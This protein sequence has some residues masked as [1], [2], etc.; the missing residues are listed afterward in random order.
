MSRTFEGQVVVVTGAGNGLGRSYAHWLA[1]AG[2]KVVVNNRVREGRP[3]SAQQ[4]VAEILAA[5]GTAVADENAIDDSV[6]ASRTINRAME[7]WGRLD[8]LICNAGLTKVAPLLDAP[9]SDIHEIMNVNFF[10]TLY[11]MLAAARFMRDAGYGR[12]VATTSS[13]ACFPMAGTGAYAASKSALI[14][15]VRTLDKE[16]TDQN[17]RV[18][19]IAPR[20]YTTM[21][22]GYM[23]ES[24][25]DIFAPEAVAR[26][27]AWLASPAC[28]NGGFLFKVGG[29][30]INEMTLG[31]GP[32]ATVDDENVNAIMHDLLKN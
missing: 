3:S 24:L 2:A 13:V 28:I 6:G 21:S 18:N 9:L 25:K 14:G 29:G 8:A 19:L 23:D 30:K 27:V 32:E 12:I 20:A 31:E 1:K 11:P 15:L 16:L 17:V 7:E 4:V 5:G 22:I 10:G 26:V